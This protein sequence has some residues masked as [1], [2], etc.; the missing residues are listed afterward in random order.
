MVPLRKEFL[1]DCSSISVQG[2]YTQLVVLIL[3]TV[4]M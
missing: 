3:I 1:E 4:Y 2:L